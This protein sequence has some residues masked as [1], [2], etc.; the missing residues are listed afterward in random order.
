M[1]KL[2]KKVLLQHCLP[3]AYTQQFNNKI[4][5]FKI[6]FW[7]RNFICFISRHDTEDYFLYLILILLWFILIIYSNNSF[8]EIVYVIIST[9]VLFMHTQ[10]SLFRGKWLKIIESNLKNI[11]RAK[12]CKK[13][14]CN[15]CFSHTFYFYV[16]GIMKDL[17]I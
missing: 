9:I 11:L 10:F 1:N 6:C 5:I 2:R 7:T 14:Y 15:W 3:V 4:L 8:L 13:N 12:N 16:L 17:L